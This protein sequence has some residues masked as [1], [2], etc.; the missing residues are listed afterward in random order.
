MF[1]LKRPLA[2]VEEDQSLLKVCSLLL[3]SCF[4]F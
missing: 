2:N 4:F 3:E 1:E